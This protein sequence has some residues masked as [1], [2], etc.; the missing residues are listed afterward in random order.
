MPF[1]SPS[2]APFSSCSQS[3]SASVFS[4]ELAVCTKMVKVLEF[5]LQ[6]HPSNENSGWFPLGLMGLISL[7]SK[8]FS[9]VFSNT[10]VQKYPFFGAQLSLWSNSHIHIWLLKKTALTTLTFVN[11]VISLLF[12]LLSKLVITFLPR[13]KHLWTSWLQSPSAVIWETTEIKSVTVSMFPHLSAMKW[14]DW[15]PWS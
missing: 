11:K 4:S 15:M 7:L 1:I 5:Q 6:H 10:T 13:S 9:R 12:N 2:F 14:W 8:G 3:L